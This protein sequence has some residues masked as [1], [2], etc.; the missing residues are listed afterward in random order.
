MF[1]VLYF[2]VLCFLVHE[3]AG[4][5]VVILMA[6]MFTDKLVKCRK[7]SRKYERESVV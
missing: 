7:Y 3:I 4:L 2:R 6:G 5:F 1:V